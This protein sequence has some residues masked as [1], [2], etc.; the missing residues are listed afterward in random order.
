[1][2]LRPC[3]SQNKTA[4]LKLW[5]ANRMISFIRQSKYIPLSTTS[6]MLTKSTSTIAT[7]HRNSPTMHRMITAR[8]MNS[9]SLV[10]RRRRS[11]SS[12]TNTENNTTS[13]TIQNTY[14]PKHTTSS[15]STT[16]SEF[17]FRA[18]KCLDTLEDALRPMKVHNLVFEITRTANFLKL[19]L[20]DGEYSLTID[21]E[22][23]LIVLYSPISG[24]YLYYFNFNDQRWQ[25]QDDEHILEGMLVRDLIKHCNGVPNL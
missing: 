6:T 7:A 16:F 15:D 10:R 18:N 17:I 25:S 9:S 4:C 2:L 22:E 5:Q 13:E 14:H 1:M 11:G 21:E 19:L 3:I 20:V 23:Q 12:G 8:S 24:Q